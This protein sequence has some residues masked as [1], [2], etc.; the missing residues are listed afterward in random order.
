[1]S[2][3][4][5]Q[6]EIADEKF[7]MYLQEE[8]EHEGPGVTRCPK[9]KRG[10]CCLLKQYGVATGKKIFEMDRRDEQIRS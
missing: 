4:P 7:A 10:L 1:M 8:I 5:A 9:R 6:F 3:P 2:K